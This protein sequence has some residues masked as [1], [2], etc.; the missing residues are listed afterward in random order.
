MSFDNISKI[1]SDMIHFGNVAILAGKLEQQLD[2]AVTVENLTSI[3]RLLDSMMASEGS[4]SY[5]S[6]LVRSLEGV[7]KK[8][9]NF[10][11][12]SLSQVVRLLKVFSYS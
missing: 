5:L 1:M 2:K 11:M 7:L 4:I 9:D 10:S 8:N 6:R 12:L 3:V